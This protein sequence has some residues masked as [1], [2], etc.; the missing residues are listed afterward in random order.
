VKSNVQT[1]NEKLRA[2]YEGQ[3]P[4]LSRIAEAHGISVRDFSSIFGVGKSHAADIL[5]HRVYPSLELALK[6]SRYWE[7]TVE[8]L[9]GWRV[10]D[11]GARRPLL[12]IDPATGKALKL[13]K[14]RGRTG[15]IEL[16]MKANGEDEESVAAKEVLG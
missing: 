9:F 5:N 7:V 11:D 8:E 14:H 15:A 1:V 6:I 2:V 16:A 3:P 13:T 4:L 12:V 10:D